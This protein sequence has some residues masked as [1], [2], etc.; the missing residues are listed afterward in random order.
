M[1]ETP[2]RWDRSTYGWTEDGYVLALDH[3]MNDRVFLMFLDAL[4]A[5]LG[6]SDPPLE[7]LTTR[8]YRVDVTTGGTTFTPGALHL[9]APEMFTVDPAMLR[10]TLDRFAVEAQSWYDEMSPDEEARAEAFIAVIRGTTP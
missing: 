3:R 10:D 9:V 5:W 8:A 7:L 4:N 1:T 6:E 2:F